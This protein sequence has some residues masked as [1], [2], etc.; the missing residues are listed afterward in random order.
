MRSAGSRGPVP[1]AVE[2]CAPSAQPLL[3]CGTRSFAV[4][5]ADLVSE[6]PG[7]SVTGFV[8]NLDPDRCARRIDGLPVHWIDDV[9][10]FAGSHLAVCALVTTLRSRFTGEM[11]ARG[12]AFATVVHPFSRVSSESRLGPGTIVSAGAVIG[13]RTAIGTHVIVNRGVLIGHHTTVGDHVS[14]LPGAN[15]AGNCDIGAAVSIGMGALVLDGVTVGQGAVVGAGAV[16]TRDVA[17]ETTVMGVPAR[18]VSAAGSSST[19][20]GKE[21]SEP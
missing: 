11:A 10:S 8:E 9:G 16:V 17:A 21:R 12:V 18:P 4:E 19:A 3:I 13:A 1:E 15:V 7:L 2:P 14:L 20:A 5:V 6:V